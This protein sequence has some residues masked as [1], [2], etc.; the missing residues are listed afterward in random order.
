MADVTKNFPSDAGIQAGSVVTVDMPVTSLHVTGSATITPFLYVCDSGNNRIQVTDYDGNYLFEFGSYG[1]GDGE[2]NSPYGV[3]N[4]GERVYVSDTGN[5]R[6]QYFDLYGNYLGQWGTFGSGDSEFSSPK[7]IAANGRY[8]FVVDQGNNRFQIFTNIGTFIMAYG[9][10]GYTSDPQYLNAPT[11]CYV[12][13]FFLWIDDTGNGYVKWYLLNLW[14]SYARLQM[15]SV[16]ITGTGSTIRPANGDLLAPSVEVSGSGYTWHIGT[17]NIILPAADVTA[18]GV[19]GRMGTGSLVS[20]GVVASG[21]G[22]AWHFGTGNIVLPAAVINANGYVVLAS[23][24]F[25]GVAMNMRN[26]AISTYSGFAFNSMAVD[27][28]GHVYGAK[29]T[30]I[31]LLEGDKDNGVNIDA[32]VKTGIFDLHDPRVQRLVDA[33]LSLRINGSGVLTVYEDEDTE[34]SAEEVVVED[35]NMH[36][37]RITFP[38]GLNGRF[39]SFKFENADGSDFDLAGLTVRLRMLKQ[40]R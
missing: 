36:D 34:G 21:S 10:L 25:T 33:F 11:N 38:Q 24:D 12:D 3:A 30:G 9:E 37:E 26:K 20:P 32:H 13:E 5:N 22:Y 15:P 2:F 7:G 29:S 4:D 27:K 18:S 39:D 14:D 40:T 31:Y 16:A 19:V 1:S 17:G 6:V 28:D 23:P 35:A 8:I